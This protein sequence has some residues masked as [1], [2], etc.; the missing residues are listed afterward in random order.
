MKQWELCPKCQGSGQQSV[1]NG[2][3]FN[4][5]CCDLCF[6]HKVI[7]CLT[8]KPPI[9]TSGYSYSDINSQKVTFKVTTTDGK[10]Y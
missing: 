3:N 8:G 1:L 4:S 6:G 5:G 9:T 7:S 2:M 10:T